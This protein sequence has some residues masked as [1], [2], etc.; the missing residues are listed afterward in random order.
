M[1]NTI[2]FYE[3][4]PRVDNANILTPME[5]LCGSSL[6]PET[7]FKTSRN[8]LTVRFKIESDSNEKREGFS[9]KIWQHAW[10]S[11]VN[12]DRG[13]FNPGGRFKYFLFFFS[14][15]LILLFVD[16]H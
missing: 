3:K 7:S 4:G 10:K 11:P 14:V 13:G 1:L 9:I 16:I 15:Y 6:P 12:S 5:G 2:L 8:Y